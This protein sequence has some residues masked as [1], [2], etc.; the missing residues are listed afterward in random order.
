[1]AIELANQEPIPEIVLMDVTMPG[2]DGYEACM[3]IKENNPEIAVIFVSA[4]DSTDEV[5]HGFDVG[6][7]DYI[8]K[9]IES[10]ILSTKLN[11]VFKYKKMYEEVHTQKDQATQTA[12]LAM[13]SSGEQAVIIEFLRESFECDS[14]EA[15]AQALLDAMSSYYLTASVQ[16]LSKY[17]LVELSHSGDV[18]PVESELM[19]RMCDY[20]ERSLSMNKRLFINY[21]DVTLFIKD[22]PIDDEDRCGRIRDYL[23]TIIHGGAVKQKSI[24]FQLSV[25][26][27]RN[28]ELAELAEEVQTT[29]KQI[30]SDN[31][32]HK[33]HS[34]YVFDNLRSRLD[35]SFFNLGLTDDQEQKLLAIVDMA[36]E[37]SLQHVEAGKE[38]DDK[39]KS[40]INALAK[41]SQK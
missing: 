36:V 41:L 28:K 14:N 15:I 25:E 21:D 23:Q 27:A 33:E 20:E 7:T 2:M 8:I 18:S 6:G 3:K 38:I 29:L 9:P 34:I 11:L 19:Q 32:N 37:E 13:T 22:M 17:K 10:Q 1:M 30:K 12:F 24:E 5:M 4:N 16:I 40:I 39:L 31:D 26:E 35:E